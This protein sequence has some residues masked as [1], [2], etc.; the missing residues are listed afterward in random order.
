MKLLGLPVFA[1]KVSEVFLGQLT[2]VPELVLLPRSGGGLDYVVVTNSS[3]V[4][5]DFGL[6]PMVGFWIRNAADQDAVISFIGAMPGAK[7]QRGL[8]AFDLTGN[9]LA[10]AIPSASLGVDGDIVLPQSGNGLDYYVKAGGNWGPNFPALNFSA[11]FWY[12]YAGGSRQWVLDPARL[13]AQIVQ[14]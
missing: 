4:G 11:G 12:K 14:Y 5:T 8:V 6:D 7:A 3:V 9:P 2:A 1:G 13:D 10:K